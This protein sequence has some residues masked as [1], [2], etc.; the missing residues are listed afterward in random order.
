MG[1]IETHVATLCNRLCGD[2]DV[3]VVVA[4]ERDQG[5]SERLNGVSVTRVPTKAVL[6]STPV[7][8]RLLKEIR[9]SHADIVH[10]HLP[11]PL[12]SLTFLMSRN[13]AALVITYHSDTVRQRALELI[14]RPLLHAI[15]RRSSAIIATS[16]HYRDS[17]PMLRKYRQRTVVIPYGID[18]QQFETCRL[19]EMEAVRRQFGSPLVIAVG[20]LVYYKGFEYLIRAMHTVEAR[21]VIIGDGPLRSQLCNL[22]TKLNLTGK[23][24]F[25]GEIDN[26]RLPAF[27]KASDLFVLPS[28]ARSEAFGIVQIE[29]MAAGLPVINTD[30][31][32]GVPFVSR[33]EVTGIT[34]P[35]C[36]D[37]A[38][39]HS[40]KQLLKDRHRC[41]IYGEA[42]RS[43]ARKEFCA[44][45]M[46]SRT[47]DLYRKVLLARANDRMLP[48]QAVTSEAEFY[49]DD[50]STVAS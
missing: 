29:A 37:I 9:N 10:L 21:L 32:S 17:S 49:E 11:N 6:F 8:P 4:S 25:L 34:V 14:S 3:E 33:H 27:Y 26:S 7:C 47:L 23:V 39:A 28:V 41:S 44:Q 30:L 42:G 13:P 2:V 35:A 48:E 46:T 12:A 36:D 45:K 5:M 38:L 22:T 15:L 20:R 40:I 1:G 31:D 16:P 24:A 50:Q 18:T 19:Q 43:R